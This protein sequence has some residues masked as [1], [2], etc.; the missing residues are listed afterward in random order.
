VITFVEDTGHGDSPLEAA[1]AATLST[2]LGT[3]AATGT[4]GFVTE[5]AASLGLALTPGVGEVLLG[6]AVLGFI[7]LAVSQPVNAE[8]EHVWTDIGRTGVVL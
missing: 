1:F 7:S 3:Y 8:A 2:V 5:L 6:L 4:L